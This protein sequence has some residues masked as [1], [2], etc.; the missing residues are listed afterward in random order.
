MNRLS[1][2]FGM[3]TETV[4]GHLRKK[5]FQFACSLACYC[6]SNISHPFHLH[7][8]PDPDRNRSY[9]A[10]DVAVYPNK[11]F[12]PGPPRDTMGISTQVKLAAAQNVVDRKKKYERWT[13]QSHVRC[14]LK[15]SDLQSTRN[16]QGE[17]N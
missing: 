16:G 8:S 1:I 5:F 6:F 9:I 2:S 17:F 10:P 7:P 3:I 12:I 13:R 4:L 15:F 14:V 11:M